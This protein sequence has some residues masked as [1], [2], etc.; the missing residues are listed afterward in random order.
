[1]MRKSLA[2]VVL[3]LGSLIPASA[4]PVYYH[5]YHHHH[6]VYRG[7]HHIRKTIKRVGIGAAGGAAIGGLAGGGTGAAIGA[8]A[9]GGAGAIY[10]HHEKAH[11]H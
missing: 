4:A 2:T 5:E 9:G 3:A 11:G 8:V 6:T 7:H 1:M 10:D